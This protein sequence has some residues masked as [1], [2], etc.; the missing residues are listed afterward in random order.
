[1]LRCTFLRPQSIGIIDL[2]VFI[3]LSVI[4]LLFMLDLFNGVSYSIE[5]YQFSLAWGYYCLNF[6]I[7]FMFFSKHLP[8]YTT[9]VYFSGRVCD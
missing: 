8:V 6:E 4:A 1:M 7:D 5:T 3:R 2:V 9:G